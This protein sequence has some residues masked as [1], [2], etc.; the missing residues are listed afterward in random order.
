[1]TGNFR[2]FLCP[3]F[4]ESVLIVKSGLFRWSLLALTSH[5]LRFFVWLSLVTLV[6][7]G[8]WWVTERKIHLA[9]QEARGLAMRQSVSLAN[10]YAGQLQHVV[11]QMNHITLTDGKFDQRCSTFK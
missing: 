11:D 9:E 4:L 6:I 8:L 10:S 7:G 2:P 3:G 1:V 5:W